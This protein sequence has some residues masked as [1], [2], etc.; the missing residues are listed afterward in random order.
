MDMIKLSNVIVRRGFHTILEI[1]DLVIP[2]GSFM[3]VIGPN[4]A[5][6]TTL[7]KVC[8]GLIKP[9]RGTVCFEGHCISGR[10][11]RLRADYRKHIGYIPQQAEYNAHLPFTLREVVAMGRNALK[12][13]FRSLDKNDH[14][15]VDFWLERMG[16]F[17]R[18]NQTF[19]SLSGGQ[20]Q[21]ALIARAMVAEPRFL[22]LDEPG[23]NLDPNW[24]QQLREIL[25]LLFEEFRLT[26]LLISHELTLIPSACER[27]IV[28]DQGR[29]IGDGKRDAV[30]ETFHGPSLSN[31]DPNREHK[32]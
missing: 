20:Q 4:G 23:S 29:I 17:D 8:C 21:K 10:I 7:L 27:L 6:K 22:L 14:E 13:L 1:S 25:D 5:G 16:L 2:A 28:L 31:F 3:S 30:L 11:L 15:K 26:G 12:P 32:D 18:R 19:R 9:T 24:K